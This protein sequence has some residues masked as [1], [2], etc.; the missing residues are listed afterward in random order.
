[1][2]KSKDISIVIPTYN[3]APELEK[4]LAHLS[5]LKSKPFE[6][7]L[8]DQSTDNHTKK[9]YMK[10]KKI[11]K[12]LKYLRSEKPSIAIA[13]NVGLRNSSK[14]TKIILFLDECRK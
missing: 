5:K 9:V 11:L 4:N 13:K 2:Y 12:M 6:V 8:V 14:K 7:I 3:R 10:Y 1:M